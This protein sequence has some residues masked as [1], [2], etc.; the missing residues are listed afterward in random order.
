MRRRRGGGGGGGGEGAGKRRR[1]EL[2]QVREGRERLRVK[3]TL[4]LLYSQAF[5][6]RLESWVSGGA[7]QVEDYF[8][9]A[10]GHQNHNYEC[11][12]FFNNGASA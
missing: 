2:K 10:Q 8:C 11:V 4:R 12:C 5:L 7:E 3:T 6:K 9:V 1:E